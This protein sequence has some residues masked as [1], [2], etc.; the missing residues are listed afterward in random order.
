MNNPGKNCRLCNV[1]H[2]PFQF[3]SGELRPCD[4]ILFKT[5]NFVLLP[6]IG[7]LVCGHAMVVS[8]MH[9]S[10]LASMPQEAIREYEE[11]AQMLFRLPEISG[12][13]LEAEHGSTRECPAGACVVHTHIHLLPG[14]MKH[15]GFLDSS[16][17]V[18][19]TFPNLAAI[20][21]VSQPYILL[22]GNLGEAVMFAADSVPTQAIRRV[23]CDRLG[24]SDWDWRVEPRNGLI[25]ETVGFWK[26]A[27][28]NVQAT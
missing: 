12:N 19:G 17:P 22:R 21:G 1:L 20:H 28:A 27:L 10:S 4:T 18:I 5:T 6:S 9:Y 11:L 3:D 14:F 2:N 26:A 8:R 16:L 25:E 7:P 24:Q 15:H 23:L 13:L